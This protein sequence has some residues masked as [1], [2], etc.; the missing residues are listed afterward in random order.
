MV[1]PIFHYLNGSL[2]KA[3]INIKNDDDNC[4]IYSV[5]CGYLDICDKPHPERV[6]QYTNYLNLFK[7]D[8][9][10]IPMKIYK[11]MHFENE[12][13]YEFMYLVLKKLQFIPCMY[14]QIE[15]MKNSK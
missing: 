13:T 15:V 14:H 1:H 2:K 10:D 12:T 4:F 9:K 7:Y 5:L 8:E 3:V 11:I 6:N